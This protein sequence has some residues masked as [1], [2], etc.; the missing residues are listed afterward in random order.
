MATNI[1]NLD[2]DLYFWLL[3]RNEMQDDPRNEVIM[4]DN[5]VEIHRELAFRIMNGVHVAKLLQNLRK[6]VIKNSSKS[7][8]L[9]P[10]L[11]HMKD[12]GVISAK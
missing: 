7:M 10:E 6:I 12:Q 2:L 9:D 8:N 1:F 11:F 5:T 3:D 4:S